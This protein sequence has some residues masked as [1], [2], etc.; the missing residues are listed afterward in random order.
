M[1][2]GIVAAAFAALLTSP[3]LAHWSGDREQ[4]DPKIVKWY[5]EQHNARGAWCCDNAD[6]HP[7]YDDYKLDAD[8]SV[9]FQYLGQHHHIPAY[10]V[11]QGANPTGHA[12]WWWV[13]RYDGKHIDYCFA[14]GGG[15]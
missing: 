12:V 15:T 14:L 3:A 6:G 5:G 8:G 9:E 1:R 10:K 2:K 4:A 7:F 13:R 11:L